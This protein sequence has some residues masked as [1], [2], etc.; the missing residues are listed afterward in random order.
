[1]LSHVRTATM[2]AERKIEIR[3]RS[4]TGVT[5]TMRDGGN[6]VSVA[7]V[8]AK[9]HRSPGATQDESPDPPAVA[10]LTSAMQC[11]G[12]YLSERSKAARFCCDG[13]ADVK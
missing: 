7:A 2:H 9:Q 4:W 8:C 12:Y 11:S 10:W 1:M 3:C 5:V 6:G 13:S